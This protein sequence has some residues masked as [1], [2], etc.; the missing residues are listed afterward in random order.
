M[1][2]K[3]TLLKKLGGQNAKAQNGWLIDH[4]I[5]TYELLQQWGAEET[6]CDAGLFHAAYGTFGYNEKLI[7]VSRREEL[8]ALIGKD[9]EAIVYTYC[10]CDRDKTYPNLKNR[11]VLFTDRFNSQTQYLTDK[12]LRNFCELTVANELELVSSND[13][14]RRQWGHDLYELFEKMSPYISDGA[15]AAYREVLQEVA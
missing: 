11:V 8:A 12:Q 9:V 4:L 3:I 2:K 15:K 14:F 1:E 13:N 6:L 7:D 10:A 5:A